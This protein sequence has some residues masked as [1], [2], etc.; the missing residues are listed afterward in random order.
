MSLL[1]FSP[2]TQIRS[3]RYGNPTPLTDLPRLIFNYTYAFFVISV[4]EYQHALIALLSALV[5]FVFPLYEGRAFRFRSFVLLGLSAAIIAFLLVAASL[6]PSIYV[7]KGLPAPRTMI[8]PQFLAVCGF[9]L[10]GWAAGSGMRAIF[11]VPWLQT[12]AAV[13]F[14][15]A[16]AFP[17]YTLIH[18]YGWE[19]IYAGR[20]EAWDVRAAAIQSALSAGASRVTVEAID[21]LPVGGI[22]DF[23]PPEKKGYWI[24]QCGE[25]FYGIKFDVVL[26]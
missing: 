6:T 21:G 26:P 4:R 8:I 11:K 14:L 1:V 13:A 15:F 25:A 10:G 2:T 17:V 22:R 16:L 24:T 3:Q 20:A 18:A 19:P 9:A 23:D 12:A 5:G 7:E